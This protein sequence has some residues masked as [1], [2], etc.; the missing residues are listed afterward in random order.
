MEH[1][2]PKPEVYW[3][4]LKKPSI[5][6]LAKSKEVDVVI[7]G[8]GIAG[9]MCAKRLKEKDPALSIIVLE[10]SICGSGATGKSSGFITPDSE[11]EL[12]DIVD[13]FGEVEGKKIWE[14]VKGGVESIRATIEKHNIECDYSVQD[15]LFIA[16]N[17]KGFKKVSQEYKVQTEVGYNATLYDA[18]HIENVIGSKN[19][20][21]GVHTKGTF[22]MIAYLFVQELKELLVKQG[23]EVYEET[24]VSEILSHKVVCENY[25]VSAK[26]IIVCTD[27]FLPKFKLAS[28]EIYHAQTFLA[29]SAPLQKNDIKKIFPTSPMMVW[30]TDLIYQYYRIVQGDRL[31]VGAASLLYTYAPNAKTF[32]PNV[33]NKMKKYINQKFPYLDIH[34]EYF[35]PGLIGVSKD[36]LPVIGQD[37]HLE[38]VY[39][40]G[41]AAGLP[42]AAALGEYIAEKAVN[43][44]SDWDATFSYKRHFPVSHKGQV[45]LSKPVSFALSHSVIKYFR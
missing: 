31:L 33:L 20:E 7:V 1:L 29:V 9:L 22:G 12:G 45:I 36:F 4:T 38:D 41:A 43:G 10:S 5:K 18:S 42:W 6:K 17:K 21:G 25:T 3:Y 8:G 32:S 2:Q 26:K 28:S 14:F 15:S 44:R 27:R 24:P 11:L 30:D 34:F 40:V 23:I 13:Q 19:Y 39:F 37:P 16:N 35:W